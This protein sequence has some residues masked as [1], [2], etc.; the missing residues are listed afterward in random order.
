MRLLL[1]LFIYSV[2]LSGQ[3]AAQSFPVALRLSVVRISGNKTLID[4]TMSVNSWAELD[5]VLRTTQVPLDAE[6]L[7]DLHLSEDNTKMSV[8]YT[9]PAGVDEYIVTVRKVLDDNAPAANGDFPQTLRVTIQ[10]YAL[11]ASPLV[12]Q[13][14]SAN[15]WEDLDT[16]IFAYTKALSPDELKS[17]HL[18][19]DKA[20][21][22]IIHSNAM[23]VDEVKVTV[24]RIT[25]DQNQ[26]LPVSTSTVN[27]VKTGGN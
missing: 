13:T 18:Q 1:V 22:T 16:F 20:K 15:R 7:A 26:W 3:V 12:D 8:T 24:Q 9:N 4:R 25:E 23:G 21:V 11:G 14:I 19:G 27:G 17:L 2:W 5:S 6:E 10:I